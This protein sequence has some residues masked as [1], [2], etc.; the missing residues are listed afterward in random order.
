[1]VKPGSLEEEVGKLS[2]AKNEEH[3]FINYSTNF[4]S[5]ANPS[6]RHKWLFDISNKAIHVLSAHDKLSWNKSHFKITFPESS[7]GMFYEYS[8]NLPC[9]MKCLEKLEYFM[10]KIK[11]EVETFFGFI[12]IPPTFTRAPAM[13]TFYLFS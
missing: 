7:I 9:I 4:R 2:P 6:R 1:M 8:R 12:G 3:D 5:P 10:L 11:K 13:L